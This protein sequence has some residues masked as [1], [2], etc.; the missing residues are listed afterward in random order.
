V[1]SAELAASM[2]L[3]ATMVQHCGSSRGARSTK[4]AEQIAAGLG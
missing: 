1:R 2:S 3:V 4:W